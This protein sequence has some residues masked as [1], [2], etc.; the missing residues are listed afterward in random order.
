MVSEL[1][2]VKTDLRLRCHTLQL[3]E[4]PKRLKLRAIA[5]AAGGLDPC[6]RRGD[7][8]GVG[9]TGGAGLT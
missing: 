2:V 7:G 6:L 8:E 5:P 4:I 1:S 9:V 3:H